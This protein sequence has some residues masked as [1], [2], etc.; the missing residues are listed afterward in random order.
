M[1]ITVE[2]NEE[3]SLIEW[4]KPQLVISEKGRIV[5]TIGVHNNE[6]FSGI[7]QI[8]EYGHSNIHY[9]SC[10]V[11]ELFKPFYGSITLQND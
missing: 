6:V 5:Q 9:S 2:K 3:K 1:N 4:N 8:D 7:Q 10:W 11:K